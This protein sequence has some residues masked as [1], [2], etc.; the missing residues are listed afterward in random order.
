[1]IDLKVSA[2]NAVRVSAAVADRPVLNQR[3][4]FVYFDGARGLAALLV[5]NRHTVS[6]WGGHFYRSYLAV[7]LFFILSGVVIALAYADRI[8]RRE[9]SALDFLKV[10]LIRL[11]PVYLLAVGLSI[12]V[13][14]GKLKLGGGLFAGLGEL[15]TSAVLSLAFLP[16]KAT[17][18]EE[19]FPLNGPFWS[20]FFELIVNALF[21]LLYPRLRTRTLSALA[22]AA[23]AVVLVCVLQH[24]SADTG[25]SWLPNSP[26]A[27]LGRAIVG[28]SIGVG[29]FLW[30]RMH[31]PRWINKTSATLALVTSTLVLTIP[32]VPGVANAL[33]DLCV[34]Y[35]VLPACVLLAAWTSDG[36]PG[37]LTR[38][39]A[40]LGVASY[41]LYVFHQPVG[42][43]IRAAVGGNAV[44]YAPFSGVAL[45]GL[46]VVMAVFV[47][48]RLDLPARR[49]LTAKLFGPG[50]P[51]TKQRLRGAV[52]AASSRDG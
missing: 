25:F 49:W 20:L 7:D 19:L 39:L 44:Q 10:R 43:L 28:F 13:A 31:A 41:P 47:E 2:H 45:T 12:A 11:Y 1:M 9:L 5:M 42:S 35:F 26:V 48:R 51:H 14:L 18:G 8:R 34:M 3:A 50:R 33:L 52:R 23:L 15:V 40:V 4:Q 32:E 38:G 36:P 22:C 46:L 17:G 29:L 6:F 21:V 16:S 37:W 30:R 24:G 27:G